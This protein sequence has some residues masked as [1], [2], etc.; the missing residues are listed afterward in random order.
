VERIKKRLW[1]D[2]NVYNAIKSRR[3]K[4]TLA[5]NLLGSESTAN[6]A[7]TPPSLVDL[8]DGRILS[9]GLECDMQKRR[10]IC[11]SFDQNWQCLGCGS[12]GGH[13]AFKIRGVADS[14]F[15]RKVV[16]L[17][18]QSV[19]A[20]LPAA[21]EQQC[22]RILIVENGKLRELADLFLERLGNR[23]VPPGTVVMIF[24]GAYLAETGI[25]NY[26]EELLS[27]IELIKAKT[28]KETIVAPLPP[29]LLG[30]S[31]SPALIRSIYELI[32]WC[33]AYFMDS[34]GFLESSF[35]MSRVMLSHMGKDSREHWEMRRLMLPCNVIPGGKRA[36]TSGGKDSRA[37][38]CSVRPMSM[39]MEKEMFAKIIGELIEKLGI[40]PGPQPEL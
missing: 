33:E 3:N 14:Y 16:I 27:C 8:G 35:I 5:R 23:R 21:G 28:G 2:N 12:H 25:V 32:T 17:A 38:P 26:C 6:P 15:S 10:T 31:D 11:S 37:M 30:G 20:A 7:Y 9:G 13:S 4:S 36:W 1:Q 24:S 22:M 19:P 40:G 18:D 29:M 39:S 34:E